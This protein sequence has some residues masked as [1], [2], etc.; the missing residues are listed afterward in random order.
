MQ[1]IAINVGILPWK[2]DMYAD[3]V[4]LEYGFF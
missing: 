3:I 1:G 4:V 2:L